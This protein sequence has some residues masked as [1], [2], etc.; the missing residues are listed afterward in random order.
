M[1]EE[2]EKNNLKS[3]LSNNEIL[4][5]KLKEENKSLKSKNEELSTKL[6]N[7]KINIKELKIQLDKTI[8][9]QLENKQKKIED[10]NLQYG[11]NKSKINSLNKALE[12]YE[13]NYEKQ[14]QLRNN[15]YNILNEKLKNE[16]FY[17]AQ[18]DIIKELK[19]KNN[20]LR[21]ELNN[22]NAELIKHEETYTNKLDILEEKQ[23][24]YAELQKQ[25][26]N[27]IKD[28]EKTSQ[29]L[30]NKTEEL[31]EI[32]YR[33]QK[34][35]SKNEKRKIEEKNYRLKINKV[36]DANKYMSS[37][38]QEN[39][40]QETNNSILN[41]KQNKNRI[42]EELNNDLNS[43]NKNESDEKSENVNINNENKEIKR[44]EDGSFENIMSNEETNNINLHINTNMNNIKE[45]NGK[46]IFDAKD[47]SN[48]N[49]MNAMNEISVDVPFVENEDKKNK[50]PEFLDEGFDDKIK[51]EEKEENEEKDDK[52]EEIDKNV[53]EREEKEEEK[54][55]ED[56]KDEEKKKE[57]EKVQMLN[58]IIKNEPK[59]EDIELEQLEEFQI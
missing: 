14:K 16:N 54:R 46:E 45:P 29:L 51:K 33:I 41:A 58:D 8:Y 3:S 22:I 13:D 10:L 49:P 4:N 9:T 59:D 44:C 38:I 6:N 15:Y 52:G 37:F 39:S 24:K 40:V 2:T 34:I 5:L 12:V 21:N 35:K 26:N 25:L 43:N 55:S 32:K 36:K 48:I 50:K 42:I 17:L 23:K 1:I 31:S 57:E 28:G 18:E 47:L 30:N 56:E 53:E 20:K 27:L 11:I 7:L 19:N